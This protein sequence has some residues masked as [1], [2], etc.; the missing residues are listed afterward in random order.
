M[1]A[2]WEAARD[3]LADRLRARGRFWRAKALELG[4]SPDKCLTRAEESEAC[5]GI[6]ADLMPSYSAPAQP[7]MKAREAKT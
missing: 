3:L 1:M 6:A 2:A 4:Q 5:A 7:D